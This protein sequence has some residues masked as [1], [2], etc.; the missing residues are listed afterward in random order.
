MGGSRFAKTI[1]SNSAAGPFAIQTIKSPTADRDN[2]SVKMKREAEL[3][4][5]QVGEKD[6]LVLFDEGGKSFAFL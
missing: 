5:K 4:L 3:L 6:M 1:R 2:G